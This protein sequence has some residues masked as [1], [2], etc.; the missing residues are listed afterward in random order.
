ML[1]KVDFGWWD[2]KTIWIGSYVEKQNGVS[3][4]RRALPVTGAVPVRVQALATLTKLD[5][6]TVLNREKKQ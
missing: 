1:P 3:H 6:S 4:S 5:L 2:Q